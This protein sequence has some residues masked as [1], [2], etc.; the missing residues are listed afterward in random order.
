MF[1]VNDI[2]DCESDIGEKQQ[3]TVK[4]NFPLLS[5]TDDVTDFPILSEEQQEKV[6]QL[7]NGPNKKEVFFFLI[8]S[9]L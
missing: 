2:P 8:Y 9:N 3:T 5:T 6:Y 7:L 1:E 4:T